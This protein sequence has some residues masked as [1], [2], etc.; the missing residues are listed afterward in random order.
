MRILLVEDNP[1]DVRL[2][3]EIMEEQGYK[4][5]IDWV[6]N[7]NGAL[8]YIFQRNDYTQA[9]R[10]DVV[11]LDLGLPRISGYEVLKEMKQSPKCANIPVFILT[12]SY[13]PLDREQCQ[14]LGAAAFLSKPR[15]FK[16]YEALVHKLV[17]EVF[18]HVMHVA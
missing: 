4:P 3:K 12:T 15:T 14:A 1:S 2:L 8:D 10:P 11:L 16:E 17:R 13:N 7:G 9:V 5:S 18:P 6:M